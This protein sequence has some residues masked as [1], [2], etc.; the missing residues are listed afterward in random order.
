[1]LASAIRP[2]YDGR[3]F[4][5]A[6]RE[7]IRA[8]SKAVRYAYACERPSGPADRGAVTRTCTRLADQAARSRRRSARRRQ[9]QRYRG[10]PRVRAGLEAD[11]SERR[12][13]EPRWRVADAGRRHGR[14][15]RPGRLHHVGRRIRARCGAVDH[16]EP[17]VQHAERSRGRRIARQ[18][19]AGPGGLALE[20]LSL[21]PR[22]RRGRQGKTGLDHLWVG[23]ARRRNTSCG[24]ALPPRRRLRGALRAVQ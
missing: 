21:D 3:S 2:I 1:M 9:C 12:D 19:S 10:A 22:L 15:G 11:W 13:R 18:H 4:Q 6:S 7:T 16:V 20:G 23:R 8:P 5:H 24:G 14:Q 17:A